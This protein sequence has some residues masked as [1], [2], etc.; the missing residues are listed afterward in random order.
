MEIITK[1]FSENISDLRELDKR[2]YRR[3]TDSLSNL[4]VNDFP[5]FFTLKNFLIMLD[6]TFQLSFF[7]KNPNKNMNK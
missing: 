5:G 4:T 7:K 1:T 2:I 3:K 6:A